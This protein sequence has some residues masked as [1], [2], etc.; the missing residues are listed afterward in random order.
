MFHLCGIVWMPC[1]VGERIFFTMICARDATHA[2]PFRLHT[3]VLCQAT[4]YGIHVHSV[5]AIPVYILITREFSSVNGFFCHSIKIPGEN[6][7]L[8]S[9]MEN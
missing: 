7:S 2:T 8:K 6:V 4:N 1:V 9:V 5:N 3:F